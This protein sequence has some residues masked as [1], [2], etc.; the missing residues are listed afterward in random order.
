MATDLLPLALGA[1]LRVTLFLLAAGGML[2]V[3]GRA[4]SAV[5][6]LVCVLALA[7]SL[8]IPVFTAWGPR[9]SVPVLPA[10]NPTSS[11]RTAPARPG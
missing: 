11:E 10:A 6:H 7:G 5:R 4:P 3:L 8:A 9:W 1:L 2:L